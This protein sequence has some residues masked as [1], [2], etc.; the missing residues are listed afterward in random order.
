[1]ATRRIRELE[2]ENPDRPKS[3]IIA[4]TADAMPGDREL[5]LEAGVDDYLTKPFKQSDLA[6]AM[7]RAQQIAR[8]S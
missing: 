4:L 6:E 2:R 8:P 5:C 1:M 7:E 3:Y